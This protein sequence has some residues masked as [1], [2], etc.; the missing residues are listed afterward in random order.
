[1]LT[2]K[3]QRACLMCKSKRLNMFY[4]AHILTTQVQPRTLTLNPSV[5][6][7]STRIAQD[8]VTSPLK[9]GDEGI[10][11]DEIQQ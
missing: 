3:L 7:M 10:N 9:L 2:T 5:R 4:S 8:P 1:M 6:I 11:Y